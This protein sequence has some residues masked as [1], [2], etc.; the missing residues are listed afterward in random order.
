M[1]S[2]KVIIALLKKT[3]QYVI[4]HRIRYALDPMKKVCRLIGKKERNKCPL[5]ERTLMALP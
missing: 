2:K 4:G 1:N 3:M 5:R